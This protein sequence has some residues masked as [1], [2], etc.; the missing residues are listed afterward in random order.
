MWMIH[1]SYNRITEPRLGLSKI[2]HLSGG[3]YRGARLG[4]LSIILRT[5]RI[6]MEP[7]GVLRQYALPPPFPRLIALPRLLLHSKY[8]C[9]SQPL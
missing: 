7:N 1:A 3:E 8:S 2:P 6:V 5:N 9:T 4:Y